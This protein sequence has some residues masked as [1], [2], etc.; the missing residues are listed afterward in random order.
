MLAAFIAV[1]AYGLF[2]SFLVSTFSYRLLYERPLFSGRFF[3]HHCQQ[4]LTWSE[5]IP[6]FSYIKQHGRC[7]HCTQAISYAYPLVEG[8]MLCF[9]FYLFYLFAPHSVLTFVVYSLY[10]A[11]LL[12]AVWTDLQAMLIPVVV[13]LGMV[14]VGLTAAALGFLQISLFESCVGALLGY[15]SLWIVAVCF[16]LLAK[17]DGMG[18]GDMHMLAMIG[19]FTGPLGVWVTA[20]VGSFS[21]VVL[22][23]IYLLITKKGKD[24]R[25][26]FGPFLA[27][28]GLLAATHGHLLLS[29]FA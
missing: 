3:C 27:L 28:G 4:S 16:R 25:V 21:G 8:V 2:L 6:L 26:P 17:K 7:R 18:V 9:V 22:T 1:G 14:P 12:I 10:A 20:F 19:S 5:L 15:I 23:T 11:A 24:T 29:F 13:T